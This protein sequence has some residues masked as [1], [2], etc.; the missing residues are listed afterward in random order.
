M[1][2]YFGLDLLVAYVGWF[3]D[4][5][6]LITGGLVLITRLCGFGQMFLLCGFSDCYCLCLTV[7]V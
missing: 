5:L 6:L 7:C 1:H 4:L 3:I 2:W